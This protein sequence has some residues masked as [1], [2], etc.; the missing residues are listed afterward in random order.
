MHAGVYPWCGQL[1]G[2]ATGEGKE[3]PGPD[4]NGWPFTSH[5]ARQAGGKAAGQHHSLEPLAQLTCTIHPH[6]SPAP[7]T[8][9]RPFTLLVTRA[10]VRSPATLPVACTQRGGEALSSPAIIRTVISSPSVAACLCVVAY[11][12]H[13]H[14][15]SGGLDASHTHTHTLTSVAARIPHRTHLSGGRMPHT[16]TPQWWPV[17]LIAHTSVAACMPQTHT[18]THTPQ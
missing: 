8:C 10:E 12:T 11:L 15:H 14:T 7:L 4:I 1:G 18:H 17:C 2:L 3:T 16:N 13:T 6:H 9:T 5:V